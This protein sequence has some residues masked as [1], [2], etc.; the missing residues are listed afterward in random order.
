MEHELLSVRR[1]VSQELRLTLMR[2]RVEHELPPVRRRASQELR[3]TL[4]RRRVEH[5]LP[6]VR[7]RARQKL[8]M[9]SLSLAGQSQGK[10]HWKLAVNCR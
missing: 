1:K 4:M 7:R 2:R 9:A 5:E 8:E 6:L 10:T 3:P